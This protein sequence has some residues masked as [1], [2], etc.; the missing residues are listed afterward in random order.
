MGRWDERKWLEAGGDN[1]TN[2]DKYFEKFWWTCD[3]TPPLEGGP[4]GDDE[5]AGF[6]LIVDCAEY[7]ARQLS[8]LAGTDS[9]FSSG[10]HTRR[11]DL[12]IAMNFEIAV[13][14]SKLSQARRAERIEPH[15]QNLWIVNGK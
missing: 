9:T 7:S 15:M 8:S 3:N 6:S 4:E 2:F 12:H 13:V 14:R 5:D 1:A 10:G 11:Y